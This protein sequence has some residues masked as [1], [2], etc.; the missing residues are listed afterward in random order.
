M[1]EFRPRGAGG[2]GATLRRLIE[3]E[4]PGTVLVLGDDRSD[5]EA[6]RVL[7]EERTRGRLHGLAVAVHGAVETPPEVVEAADL[8]L[9]S[10]R[11]A[12]AV[13]N[14]LARAASVRLTA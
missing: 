11:D 1:I 2:K 10:P 6:F 9:P 12:A 7:A 14:A 13:L 5:A 3:R 4:R 8:L